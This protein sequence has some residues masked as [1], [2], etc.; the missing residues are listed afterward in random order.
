M[1][2]NLHHLTE[3]NQQQYD[4]LNQEY[5]QLETQIPQFNSSIQNSL[6]NTIHLTSEINT[7]RCLLINLVQKP[8]PKP[9]PADFTVHFGNGIIWVRI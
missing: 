4:I 9:E 2:T 6:D 3:Q 7:Y 5:Q 1:E 8:K